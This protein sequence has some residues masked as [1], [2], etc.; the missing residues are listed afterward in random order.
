MYYNCALTAGIIKNYSLNVSWQY[1]RIRLMYNSM[2]HSNL[3]PTAM[4]GRHIK[5]LMEDK[6]RFNYK[7]LCFRALCY[8]VAFWTK[9]VLMLK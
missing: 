3:L 7:N 9:S 2:S 4:T 5:D 8:V 6:L 1:L